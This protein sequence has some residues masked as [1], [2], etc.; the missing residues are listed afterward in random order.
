MN[1]TYQAVMIITD[2]DGDGHIDG[3]RFYELSQS[4]EHLA[5]VDQYMLGRVDNFSHMVL[6]IETS[7]GLRLRRVIDFDIQDDEGT[8]LYHIWGSRLV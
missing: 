1:K 5:D 6:S 8:R 3:E 2:Y 4:F 7:T